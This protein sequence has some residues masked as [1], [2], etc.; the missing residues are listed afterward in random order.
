M[1]KDIVSAGVVTVSACV[2]VYPKLLFYPLIKM[3][4]PWQQD[5]VQLHQRK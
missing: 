3:I 4:G 5:T 2:A 1:C